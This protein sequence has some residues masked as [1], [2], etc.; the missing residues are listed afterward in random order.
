MAEPLIVLEQVTKIY[1]SGETS[2]RALDQVSLHV[3]EGEFFAIMG[4]SG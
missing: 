3:A 2:V 1:G 4:P